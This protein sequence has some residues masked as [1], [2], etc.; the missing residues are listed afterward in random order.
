MNE[1]EASPVKLFSAKVLIIKSF[2]CLIC[3]KRAGTF[4]LRSPKEQGI[5]RFIES[6][7]AR[8]VC[9]GYSISD[10]SNYI[11][12]DNKVWKNEQEKLK[13]HANCYASYC[14]SSNISF[15]T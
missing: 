4:G 11:D 7:V 3:G 12:F 13:W 6:L 2:E 1:D 8:K 9:N 5:K 14:S 10:F 15:H